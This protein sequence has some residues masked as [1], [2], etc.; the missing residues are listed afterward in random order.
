MPATESRDR[1]PWLQVG[2]RRIDQVRRGVRV[3]DDDE[4]PEAR[5][6]G[7]V[8]LPLEPMQRLR[9][10]LGRDAVLL[11]PVEAAAVH[12]PRLAAD[13]TLGVV[14]I[15]RRRKVVV[16]RDEVEGRTDPR[17]RGDH[18]QPPEQ[19]VAPAPPV[20]GERYDERHRST[21]ICTSSSTPVASSCSRLRSS[22]SRRIGTISRRDRRLTKT[23]KRKPNFSS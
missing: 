8:R 7:R 21:A 12:L 3:V 22:R 6:P 17:H 14:G 16:E 9:Q 5:Q 19:Q 15:L 23:T 13:P 20:V 1:L 10:L 2:D 18:M 11:D 4:Q